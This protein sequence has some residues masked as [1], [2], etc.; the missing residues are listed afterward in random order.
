MVSAGLLLLTVSAW[1]IYAHSKN[2]TAELGFR[3]DVP[4]GYSINNIQWTGFDGFD[5]G[6]DVMN[7]MREIRGAE[8]MPEFALETEDRNDED[9]HINLASKL[10]CENYQWA[11][12]RHIRKG[13]KYLKHL[14]ESVKCSNAPRS[15]G[16]VSCSHWSAIWW[17]NEKPV[18]SEAFSCGTIA[19]YASEVLN[20]CRIMHLLKR[21]SGKATD[22]QRGLNVQ[23]RG[24]HCWEPQG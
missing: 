11:W 6:Q 20:V 4:E 18:P 14:P 8:Y 21:I 13:I 7:Q 9:V 12:P 19:D 5:E 23:V 15:C 2:S 1:T 17:C 16:R 24:G 3:T 22:Y 10:D